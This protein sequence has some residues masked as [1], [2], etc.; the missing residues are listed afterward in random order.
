MVASL[1]AGRSTSPGVSRSLCAPGSGSPTT[2]GGCAWMRSGRAV[3]RFTP[4]VKERTPPRSVFIGVQPRDLARA[5]ARHVPGRSSNEPV[6]DTRR[7]DGLSPWCDCCPP[8][9]RA[10]GKS[11]DGGRAWSGN[12]T[13]ARIRTAAPLEP[14]PRVCA[15]GCG[16]EGPA[17]R[18][19]RDRPAL[20]PPWRRL[21]PRSQ[22]LPERE[23]HSWVRQRV[24]WPEHLRVSGQ[25]CMHL[26]RGQ[27]GAP[28]GP[29]GEAGEEPR[30]LD[31]QAERANE[32]SRQRPR[33]LGHRHGVT[34]RTDLR[35]SP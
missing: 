35:A 1:L 21:V 26:G 9:R 4:Q 23:K 14:Q 5:G 22:Q 8:G 20:P 15:L 33:L 16:S 18:K 19:S 13:P 32:R 6:A 7:F 34:S 25:R 10:V 11:R 3:Q 31:G 27:R 30:L 28:Q 29:Q 2:D 24:R 12:R 17:V